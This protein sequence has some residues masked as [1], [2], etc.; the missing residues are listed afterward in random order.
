MLCLPEFDTYHVLPKYAEEPE[1]ARNR[2]ALKLLKHRTLAGLQ[3]RVLN[4]RDVTA[5]TAD[6]LLKFQMGRWKAKGRGAASFDV[7]N[8][9]GEELLDFYVKAVASVGQHVD[10]S[11]FTKKNEAANGGTNSNQPQ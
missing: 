5:D 1:D 4:A 9:T 10:P 6:D 2:L 8:M 11:L 3:W 7:N